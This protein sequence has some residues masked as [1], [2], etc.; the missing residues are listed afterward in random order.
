MQ[1][2]SCDVLIFTAWARPGRVAK[3]DVQLTTLTS[4]HAKSLGSDAFV[5]GFPLLLMA[6]T[7]R[8]STA[9]DG[10]SGEPPTNRFEHLNRFP[11]PTFTA[12]VGA[13][14]DT[15][16]S[17]AW[18]DLVREPALLELPDV[19]ERS[20]LLTLL[21]AWSN[22]FAS[23]G[24]RTAGSGDSAYAIAGPGW[25]GELPRGTRRLDA[26][27]NHVWAICHLHTAGHE[28][29]DAARAV[30]QGLRLMPLGEHE[31]GDGDLAAPVD[32][33]PRDEPS[34]HRHVMSLRAEGFLEE[35]AAGMAVNP[36]LDRDR[37]MLDR[38][39]KIG[40]R[41]GRPLTWSGLS[42]DIRDALEGGIADG[43]E[44]VGLPP[45][46]R[47]ENGWHSL[48]ESLG[49][50]GTDYLRRA[51]VAN[52]ALGISH[53]ADAVFPLTATDG[54]GRRLNGAHRYRLRFEADGLPPVAALWSLALY[55]MDQLFV[56]NPIDRFAL[57]NRDQ[58]ELAPDGSLE[59]AIQHERPDGSDANWL[60]APEGDFN[61]MLHMY[62]PDRSVLDGSWTIPPVQRI[63]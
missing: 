52:V 55:D 5:F 33:E 36:P 8:R 19:G 14:S 9:A 62:W 59:I 24:P 50:F 3:R 1:L 58:L 49:D 46:G 42:A 41:P 29:L 21:D 10:R 40:L 17:L 4:T 13:N 43:K 23:L 18:L 22:V 60:P 20:Y 48:Q 34:P 16:Y 63:D 51:Q 45:S 44:A 53:A 32:L 28:D 39:A 15:L 2:G 54:E 57:G 11:D 6:A 37:P 56:P 61:L 7:M 30:Q 25:T 38:L 12:V 35:L 27:T 26:P 47:E 31:S